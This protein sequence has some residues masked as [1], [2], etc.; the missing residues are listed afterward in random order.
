MVR[1]SL[2]ILPALVLFKINCRSA[3]LARSRV[4]VSETHKKLPEC[5]Q[6]RQS[7]EGA[8][9]SKPNNART[10]KKSS[11]LMSPL[12]SVHSSSSGLFF[13]W[14]DFQCWCLYSSAQAFTTRPLHQPP[15]E[16]H[17]HHHKR[18]RIAVHLWLAHKVQPSTQTV[19]GVRALLASMTSS[20][21]L[22]MAQN[23]SKKS[24]LPPASIAACMVPLRLNVL[25]QRMI[26]AR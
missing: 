19:F 13:F 15:F 14:V 17:A 11:V 24:L 26:R 10:W 23:R 20:K 8:W 9:K 25:R 22:D 3:N 5:K 21:W 7:E 12:L 16:F 6:A 1:A 4:R 18:G 2:G